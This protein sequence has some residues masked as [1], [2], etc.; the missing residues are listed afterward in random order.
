MIDKSRG[1]PVVKRVFGEIFGGILICDFWGAYNKLCALAKQ[2]CFYH[3]F[4]ELVTVDK[5]NESKD[6]KAFR[7]KLSRLLK[8]AVRLSERR[9]QFESQDYQRRKNR[10]HC[11]LENLIETVSEDKDVKR[12]TKRLKRHKQELFTFLDYKG[13]SPYNNYGEQ[14]MR[15]PAINRK[16]S[17]QNKT[18]QGAKTQ[19]ILMT[20]F[21]SCHIQKLNPCEIVLELTKLCID[22]KTTA[23]TV[24]TITP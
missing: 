3:L 12:L 20:L 23:K 18:K 10:L 11:R 9:N 21:K 6:W 17:H 13:V 24:L 8:D 14:Q 2:R 22:P 4:T 15:K 1:S 16:I 19:A 5:K 7:K